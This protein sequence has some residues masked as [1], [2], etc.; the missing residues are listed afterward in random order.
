MLSVVRSLKSSRLRWSSLPRELG[1]LAANSMQPRWTG[2]FGV[3]AVVVHVFPP[4]YVT[5]TY[6]SHVPTKLF[7]WSSPGVVLPRNAKAARLSSPATTVGISVLAMWNAVPTSTDG[8]QLVPW[9]V[10]TAIL[11]WPLRSGIRWMD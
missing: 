11:G 6:T 4:L 8:P 2:A 1:Q 9:L 10:Q 7:S 3:A 5:A